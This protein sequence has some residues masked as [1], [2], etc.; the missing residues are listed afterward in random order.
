MGD[1]QPCKDQQCSARD[2]TAYTRAW[3][4]PYLGQAGAQEGVL[5]TRE[6][7]PCCNLWV[8]GFCKPWAAQSPFNLTCSHQGYGD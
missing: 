6:F 1:V 4:G 2:G 8:R 5:A 7:G 3:Q